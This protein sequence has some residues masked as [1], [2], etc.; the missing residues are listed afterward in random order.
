VEADANVKLSTVSRIVSASRPA[1]MPYHVELLV[2]GALQE[3]Q[4]P[5]AEALADAH[6]PSAVHLPG[7]EHIELAPQAPPTQEELEA[8]DGLP[9]DGGPVA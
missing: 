1:H 6:A 4:E 3:T 8:P 2:G 7:S 5:I 9:D